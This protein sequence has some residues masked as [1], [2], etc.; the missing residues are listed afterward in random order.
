MKA[1]IRRRNLYGVLFVAAFALTG[2]AGFQQASTEAHVAQVKA[3]P[4]VQRALAPQGVLRVGVYLGSPTSLVRDAKSG[5]S[6]GVAYELGYALAAQLN[7][8]VQIVQYQ[9]VAE[10][11][12]ALKSN[13]VDMTFTNATAARAKDVDFTPAL[14]QLELGLLVPVNSA[15]KSFESVDRAGVLLGVSQGSSSQGV[16]SQRLKNATIVPVPSLTQVQQMLTDRKLDVFATNK[17]ILFE[18]AEKMADVRV[19]DDS[20]GVENLAIAIPKGRDA[21]MPYLQAF[22]QRAQKTGQVNQMAQRA[23]LRGLVRSN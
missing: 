6:F 13:Q 9:R 14:I 21:G 1:F 7:V 3:E 5:A 17:G 20:W 15:I 8:P 12:D 18:L 16:L 4:S 19:L 11:I 23:G 22:A 2:C 10:V